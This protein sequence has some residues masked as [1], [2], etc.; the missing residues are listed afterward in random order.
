[1]KGV[2]AVLQFL[3]VQHQQYHCG[4]FIGNHVDRQGIECK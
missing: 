4:A 3:N 1:M 2:E